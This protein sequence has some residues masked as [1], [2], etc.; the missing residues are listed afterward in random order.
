MGALK[1]VPDELA[2]VEPPVTSAW[3]YWALWTMPLAVMAGGFVWQRRRHYLH[4][5]AATVRSS[6]AHKQARRAL[7]PVRH[8][9]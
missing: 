9:R 5:N 7:A 1:S 4:A 3:W 8:A 2:R 6:R